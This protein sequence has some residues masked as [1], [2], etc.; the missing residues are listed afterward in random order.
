ME[1]QQHQLPYKIV[2]LWALGILPQEE[3]FIKR[4]YYIF[5]SNRDSAGYCLIDNCVFEGN[6]YAAVFLLSG[7]MTIQKSRYA[8]AEFY[9]FTK[10]SGKSGD[11]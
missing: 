10:V 8:F 2:T 9:S 5:C 7:V 6:A 11:E 3:L 4:K 1:L